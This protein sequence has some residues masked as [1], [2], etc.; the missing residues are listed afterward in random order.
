M[1]SDDRP[2][3]LITDGGHLRKRGGLFSAVKAAVTGGGSAIGCVLLREQHPE[4]ARLAGVNPASDG[5]VLELASKLLPLCRE[6]GAKLVI[7]RRIDLAKRSGCDGVH[8]GKDGPTSDE[9]RSALGDGALIGYSAHS[10]EELHTLPRG[11]FDYALLSPIFNPLSKR[12]SNAPLGLASLRR[13]T[14][15]SPVRIFALGGIT[16][17]N[18]RQCIE[19]GAAGV[20]MISSVLLSTDP[21]TQARSL[22]ALCRQAGQQKKAVHG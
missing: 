21:G 19:S 7:N 13:A 22:A 1:L 16:P 14:E 6:H 17:E 11:R 18:A 4:A 12:S 9:A 15:K 3:F 5:E 8:L 2:I 20:A 10:P